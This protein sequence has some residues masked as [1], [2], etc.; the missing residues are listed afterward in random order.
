MTLTRTMLQFADPADSLRET[1]RPCTRVLQS[2]PA[3]GKSGLARPAL[4]AKRCIVDKPPIGLH[5]PLGTTF[6]LTCL[7]S[8]DKGALPAPAIDHI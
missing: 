6:D 8:H 2:L 4:T 1:P 5:L 3:V 7:K